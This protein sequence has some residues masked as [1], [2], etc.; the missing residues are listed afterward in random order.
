MKK[1]INNIVEKPINIE[2]LSKR[3][4]KGSGNVQ[5]AQFIIDVILNTLSKNKPLPVFLNQYILAALKKY[6]N[7]E[8]LNKAFKLVRDG[9]P[10]AN[11]PDYSS[12][13]S[14]V[15]DIAK[16]MMSGTNKT[17]AIAYIA[18][19]DNSYKVSTLTKDFNIY[20]NQAFKTCVAEIYLAGNVLSEKQLHTLKRHSDLRIKI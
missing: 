9:R 12:G 17:S 13:P 4:S 6:K 18:S 3:V 11:S 10:K 20:R 2:S 1:L 7:C 15:L 8:D 16:E 14:Y 5:E 19:K